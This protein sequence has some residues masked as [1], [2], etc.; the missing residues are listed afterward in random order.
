[1]AQDLEQIAVARRNA[2]HVWPFQ[3]F[4]DWKYEVWNLLTL[5]KRCHDAFHN[6]AGGYV[7]IAIGPFF[8][9]TN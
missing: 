1:M 3:R 5:C 6:A 2:H 7:R 4:P 8:A 9:N